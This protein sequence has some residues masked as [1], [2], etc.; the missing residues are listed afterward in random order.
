MIVYATGVIIK[1]D[2]YFITKQDRSALQDA[3]GFLLQNVT[4][5]LQNATILL[6]NA[7]VTTKCDVYH[8]LRQYTALEYIVF[9]ACHIVRILDMTLCQE[10]FLS[11][12]HENLSID[13]SFL[14]RMTLCQ[15]LFVLIVIFVMFF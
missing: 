7:T 1:C 9:D 15:Q 14:R 3:S 11:L 12:T 10:L 5:L 13:F 4:V 8:K 6:H 2:S